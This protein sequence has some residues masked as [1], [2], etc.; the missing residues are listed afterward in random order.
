MSTPVYDN[1]YHESKAF[2]VIVRRSLTP[3]VGGLFTLALCQYNIIICD[4]RELQWIRVI[5]LQSLLRS[6]IETWYYV[7]MKDIYIYILIESEKDR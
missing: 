6:G 4:V 5:L 1:R 7:I 2:P 3:T